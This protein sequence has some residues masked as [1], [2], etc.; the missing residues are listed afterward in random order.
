[1]AVPN[2]GQRER[3][4]SALRPF[5]PHSRMSHDARDQVERVAQAIADAVEEFRQNGAYCIDCG[6]AMDDWRGHGSECVYREEDG[7]ADETPTL[8]RVTGLPVTHNPCCSTHGVPMDCISYRRTHFVEVRPCCA[9]D[10][11]A[12]EAVEVE[13]TRREMI[14]ATVAE[15]RPEKC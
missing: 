6:N 8:D 4:E 1:M 3:A 10:R 2:Q 7:P 11:I 13:R 5:G 15:M 12:L 9:T 14:A